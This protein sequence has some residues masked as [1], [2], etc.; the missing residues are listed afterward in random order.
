[1]IIRND[2]EI[3]LDEE[4]IDGVIRRTNSDSAEL[5]PQFPQNNLGG[6][7]RLQE[8]LRRHES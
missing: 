5:V 8:E 2:E 6:K 7:N 1:M 3:K 4:D